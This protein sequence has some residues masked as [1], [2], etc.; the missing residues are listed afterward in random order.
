[1]DY[2][3]MLRLAGWPCTVVG[4]GRVAERKVRRLLQSAAAVTVIAPELTTMLYAW[5]QAEKIHWQQQAYTPG[6]L[7]G[8]RLVFCA[9]DDTA[10]QQAVAAEARA[11][12]AL[13]NDAALPTQSDFTVPASVA[14]GA[15]L[16]TVSTGGGS[17]ELARQ[18]RQEL[19]QFYPES[20]ACWLERLTA[21]RQSLPQQLQSSEQRQAF[22]RTALNGRIL[23]L[24]RDG[25]LD[26]AEEEVRHAIIG[27][28]TKS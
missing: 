23:T 14:R 12:G 1:M 17:P 5:A 28:G 7:A 22:W 25:Q 4:G 19:E 16:L 24:V 27:F 26:R 15:L 10:C 9:T 11:Q 13:L 2:P 21:L 20:F 6:C 18:I 8:A 3:V